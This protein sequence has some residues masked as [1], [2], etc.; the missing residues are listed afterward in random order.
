MSSSPI[1]LVCGELSGEAV[2]RHVTLSERVGSP[3]VLRVMFTLEKVEFDEASVLNQ[4]VEL[5]L[6]LSGDREEVFYGRAADIHYAGFSDGDHLFHLTARSTLSRLD[7]GRRYRIFQSKSAS[8]IIK[9]VLGEAGIDDIDLSLREA[10]ASRDYCV[11]FGESDLVFVQR[12]CEQEGLFYVVRCADGAETLVISD[13]LEGLSAGGEAVELEFVARPDGEPSHR[14]E[15]SAFTVSRA[16]VPKGVD[17]KGYDFRVPRKEFAAQEDVEGHAR[18]ELAPDTLLPGTYVAQGVGDR[19]VKTQAQALAA[20]AMTYQARSGSLA[21]RAGRKFQ[22]SGHPRDALNRDYVV[23]GS[24]ITLEAGAARSARGG[25]WALSHDIEVAAAGEPFR[26]ATSVPRPVVPGPQIARVV[27]KSGEEVFTDEHGRVKV[28]FR[29]DLADAQDESSSCWL[30]VMQPWAGPA[31]GVSVL[32]RIGDEVVVGFADGNP[33]FP[34]VLG[35][36]YNGDSRA[37]ADLPSTPTDFVIR[38]RSSKQGGADAY[39]EVR[40][41]DAKGQERFGIQAQKD[42]SALVKNDS[43]SVV[44]NNRSDKVGH[45]YRIEA[46]DLL[47]IVVGQSKLSMDSSGN[48]LLSGVSIKIEGQRAVEV[49]G[50]S[51]KAQADVDA[52]FKGTQTKVQGVML[53]LKADGIATLSAAL[54]KIG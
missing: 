3:S 22:M 32:P 25:D 44:E 23:I 45:E 35:S 7:G 17:A 37:P 18:G 21:L 28:K 51:V 42:F 53:D 19:Y 26:L 4:P 5:V 46:G 15:I 9:T 48:I 8:D 47:E 49:K 54:T 10:C 41:S 14:D 27:G 40:L 29:W 11:Q 20:A 1:K 2:V 39:N 43:E 12:L 36:L 24:Q 13:S 33:D 34:F 52:T 50:M 31:R 16:A 38:T 6:S 30:R